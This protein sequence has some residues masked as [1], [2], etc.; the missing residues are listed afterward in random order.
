MIIC[1][2]HDDMIPQISKIL[3]WPNLSAVLNKLICTK[4]LHVT[5]DSIFTVHICQKI[6]ICFSV[7]SDHANTVDCLYV[8]INIDCCMLSSICSS[9]DSL[10]HSVCNIMANMK[11]VRVYHDYCME[12]S[13]RWIGKKLVF[14]PLDFSNLSAKK[15]LFLKMRRYSIMLRYYIKKFFIHLSILA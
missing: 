15:S 2:E 12:E 13:V 6:K 11:H 5:L 14:S 9:D 4:A 3:P 10:S 1:N 7:T 8:P